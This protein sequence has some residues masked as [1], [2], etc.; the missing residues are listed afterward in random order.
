MF[1]NYVTF[2]Q[3]PRVRG[4]SLCRYQT[5][6]IVEKLSAEAFPDVMKPH[7]S[8]TN[9]FKNAISMRASE[10]LTASLHQP[11]CVNH[12]VMRLRLCEIGRVSALLTSYLLPALQQ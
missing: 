11:S 4:S 5:F 2:H 6:N 7:Q 12:W 10:T 9:S 3:N 8:R 1:L